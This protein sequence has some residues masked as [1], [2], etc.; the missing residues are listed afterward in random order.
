MCRNHIRVFYDE[1][2]TPYQH[3]IV[4]ILPYVLSDG[5]ISKKLICE[6][7]FWALIPR[8]VS[9]TNFNMTNGTLVDSRVSC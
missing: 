3:Q 8:I 9:S 2:L 4:V 1:F 7:L 5:S 6:S